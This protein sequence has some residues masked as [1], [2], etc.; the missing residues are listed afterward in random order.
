MSQLASLTLNPAH[1]NLSHALFD[2]KHLP[3]LNHLELNDYF[4]VSPDLSTHL[5]VWGRH[6]GVVSLS[7]RLDHYGLNDAIEGKLVQLFPSVKKLY[8]PQYG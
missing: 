7:L 3:K 4:D 1:L 2:G 5:D 8:F 6:E